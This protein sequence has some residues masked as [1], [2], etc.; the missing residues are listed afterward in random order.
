[1]AV[2]GIDSR[3]TRGFGDCVG[4]GWSINVIQKHNERKNERIYLIYLISVAQLMSCVVLS[5]P[6]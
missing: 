6:L 3:L 1:M 5:S 4:G 2:G